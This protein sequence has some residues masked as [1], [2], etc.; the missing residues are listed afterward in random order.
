MRNDHNGTMGIVELYGYINEIEMGYIKANYHPEDNN[1]VILNYTKFATYERR[2]N[3]Y[4]MTARGLILDLTDV[5]NNGIVYIL[6]RPFE[7]FPN[8]GENPEY[9]ED[10]DWNKEY[11]VMEKMDGSLGI[12]YMFKGELRFATRGSF[13]SDQALKATEMWHTKYKKANDL[14]LEIHRSFKPTLLVEI[15][16]P[17]NRVVVDY[18]DREELVLLA[19]NFIETEASFKSLQLFSKHSDL[20]LVPM[21]KYNLEDMLRLREEISGNEEGWVI[22]F[23]NN[24]RLKIKGLEY[25]KVHGMIHGISEKQKVENWRNGTMRK[26]VLDLPEEFRDDLEAF[27][28]NLD[29]EKDRLYG[30]L[31][32]IFELSSYKA[33]GDKKEFALV[34]NGLVNKKFRGMMFNAWNNGSIVVQDIKDYIFRNYKEYLEGVRTWNN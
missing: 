15:V 32:F 23:S 34:V 13:T 17:E 16:Y 31:Q 27:A 14:Y 11:V 12:S 20:S 19:I 8:M 18:R 24:K 4:T 26:Y 25:I 21:Y 1:I 29:R 3:K 5:L 33:S 10:I 2:W 6:A 28:D 7:K 9:E 30:A 22:K